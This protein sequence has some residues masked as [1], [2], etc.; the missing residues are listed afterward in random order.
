MI[1]K[2]TKYAL[3]ALVALAEDYA[4]KE[5]LLISRLAKRERIPKKFLEHILL[6]LKKKGFLQSKKG[7]GGGYFLAKPPGKINL[8]SVMR[9][10]QGPLSPVPCL[11]QTA[12]QKCAECDDEETCAIRLIMK[13]VHEATLKILEGT[14]LQQMLE[15]AKNFQAEM[16]FI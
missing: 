3:K 7:K 8:G 11:S 4:N 14:T 13:D 16:Y 15:R 1:S 2:K 12:Y 6:D 5:P 9:V 10:L